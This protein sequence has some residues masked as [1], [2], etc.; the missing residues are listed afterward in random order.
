MKIQMLKCTTC[1]GSIQDK[2]I[3]YESKIYFCASCNTFQ[4]LTPAQIG[5]TVKSSLKSKVDIPDNFS[6][7]QVD[8]A[9]AIVKKPGK[10]FFWMGATFLVPLLFIITFGIW[11]MTTSVLMIWPMKKAP[12]L[13]VLGLSALIGFHLILIY[14][15]NTE[16]II[17]K[18]DY[19]VH[20]KKPYYRAQYL[21]KKQIPIQEI[22]QL[23]VKS[24]IVKGKDR[25]HTVY[26]VLYKN[27]QG[28][29]KVFMQHFDKHLEAIYIE[30]F[31]EDQLDITDEI[32]SDE[33][34]NI[35]ALIPTLSDVIGLI[36]NRN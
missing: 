15:F 28:K 16:R 1:K 7:Q 5:N 19:L 21:M 6:I 25:E 24:R 34:A 17:I 20:E 3:N 33:A 11:Q 14:F 32:Q 13:I 22:Q 27:T 30:Q 9:K 36:R 8:G 4:Q 26:D 10:K 18:E 35:T 12:E 23:Y 2:D 31:L 29:S